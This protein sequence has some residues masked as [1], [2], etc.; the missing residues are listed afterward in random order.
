VITRFQDVY[1]KDKTTNNTGKFIAENSSA[2]VAVTAHE[3][4]ATLIS[5]S[6][7]ITWQQPAGTFTTKILQ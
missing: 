5:Q 6:Q 2:K 3:V 7:S 1:T 4:S